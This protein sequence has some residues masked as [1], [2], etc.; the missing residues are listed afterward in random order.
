MYPNVAK[1]SQRI[2]KPFWKPRTT[3]AVVN[4]PPSPGDLQRGYL[5]VVL[6]YV[7]TRVG[8]GGQAEAEDITAEVFGAAFAALHRCPA[9]PV[10][11]AAPSPPQ[12]IPSGDDPVRAWLFGIA[13]RKLADSYRRRTSRPQTSLPLGHP[14]PA[15]HG[16]EPRFLAGEAA[17]MLEGILSRLPELQREALLLRYIEGLNLSEIGLILHKSPNAVAQLLHRA[18]QAARTQ[19]A[20]YFGTVFPIDDNKK[21]VTL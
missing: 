16:P 17:Q 2:V 9:V 11:D 15:Q 19:G 4:T 21:V 6:T 7:A 18:R 1:V 20:S 12:N 14:A 3:S 10:F 13:R 8:P 5:G